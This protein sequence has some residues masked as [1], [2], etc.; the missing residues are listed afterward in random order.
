MRSRISGLSNVE[1]EKKKLRALIRTKNKMKCIIDNSKFST[2]RERSTNV[3]QTG[4]SANQS[5]GSVMISD[6]NQM[7]TGENSIMRN[8]LLESI[9]LSIFESNQSGKQSVQPRILKMNQLEPDFDKP[10]SVL[11]RGDVPPSL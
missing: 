7:V 3:D 1:I 8:N 11:A 4:R 5:L 6:Y 9:D 2:F 10:E